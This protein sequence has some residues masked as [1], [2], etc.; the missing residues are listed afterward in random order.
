MKIVIADYGM[1]NIKSII[2]ALNYLGADNIV[3]SADYETLKIADKIILPGVGSFRKAMIQIRENNLDKYLEELAV[4]NNKP[5]IGICLGM[6]L[7]GTSSTEDGFTEGL[8]FVNAHCIKFDN[9]DLKV[10]HVG[11]N[12]LKTDSESKLYAGLPNESDFY[13]T[14]SYKMVSENEIN[15]S[16]CHYG[17]DFIASFEY[18]NIVGVQFHPELSQKNGLRLLKNFI[19]KF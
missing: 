8:G 7:L 10:P 3:V 17:S 19:E 2:S 5:L 11:F 4:E 14:H 16:Y 13:F 18:N 6:Q 15:Q 12:Q 9:T 1:G